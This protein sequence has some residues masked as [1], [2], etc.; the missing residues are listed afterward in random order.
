M[1]ASHDAGEPELVYASPV[2]HK[3]PND[4]SADGRHILFDA[5][6]SDETTELWVLSMTGGRQ[7]HAIESSDFQVMGGQFSPDSR[8]IA[9]TAEESGRF[10]VYVRRFPSG[11][12]RWRV[13]TD[14]GTQVRWRADGSELFYLDLASRLM[15]VEFAATDDEPAIGVPEVLF[16]TRMLQAPPTD[17]VTHEYDVTSDGERFLMSV[18]KDEPEPIVVVVNWFEEIGGDLP[19]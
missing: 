10:E 14:G 17:Y 6:A 7:A 5:N 18:L 15:A 9:Y 13:S 1:R 3:H 8:W 19:Q 12:R 11:E 4:W 16:P 2:G